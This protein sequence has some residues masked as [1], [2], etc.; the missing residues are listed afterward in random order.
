MQK[1]K[2]QQP[3]ERLNPHPAAGLTAQQA[4]QRAQ[5]GWAN[6]PPPSLG[7]T[8]ARIFW[9][10]IF[11]FYNLVFV[12]LAGCL[13]AVGAWRDMLF[14]G[15]VVCNAGI[16]ILQELRVRA[17]LQKAAVLT[18]APV[19]VVRDGREQL[20]PP[21]QLVLDDVVRFAAG[22]QVCADA[23]VLAGLVE[24]NEALLTGEADPVKKQPGDPLLSGSVVV[25]GEC[26]ARLD[27][28]GQQSYA[29]RLTQ[30]ARRQKRRP[31]GLVRD[32]DR[33]LRAVGVLLAPFGVFMGVRQCALPGTSLR[34]A[35]S[36]T[37]AALCGM[38]PEG[39]YLLVSV[40]LAVGVLRLARQRTLVHEMACIENLARV[41]TLCLDKTGTLTEG[42]LRAEALLAVGDAAPQ[43]NAPGRAITGDAAPEN[44]APGDLAA[45]SAAPGS[46]I[47]GE[48]PA[49]SAAPDAAEARLAALLGG[50]A[51]AAAAPNATIRALADAYSAP[52]LASTAQVPFS[53]QRGWSAQFVP[54]APGTAA[55]RAPAGQNEDGQA[56]AAGQNE[57]GQEGTGPSAPGVWYLLGAPERLAPGQNAD[58]LKPW[59]AAGR[60]V[61]AFAA[62]Q[63]AV[64]R[65]ALT[66][67]HTLLGYVVL[68]DTLRPGVQDT[69]RYFQ[70]QGVAV[71]VLS[72]DAPAAV[73]RIAQ[74]AGVPNAQRQADMSALSPQGPA[75]WAAFAR[76]HTVFGRVSPEQKRQLIA[77]L[78][79]AGHTVAMLGD[80]VN[81][82]PALK[83][84]DCSIAMAAGSE[85]ARQ[86]SQIVLL[87]S[88]FAA[89]PAILCEGRRVIQNVGR[90]AS[91]F[92]VKNIFSFFTAAAMLLAGRPYPLVPIQIT[93]ISGLLIGAPSFLLTF[94]PCCTRPRG[95]F[96]PQAIGKALPGGLTAAAAMLL[97]SF[98]GGRMGLPVAEVSSACTLLAGVNGLCVL[99]LLC[100][101]LTRLRAAV[102]GLMALG[103]FGATSFLPGFFG[104]QPFSPRGWGLVCALGAAVPAV[105]CALVW[106]VHLGRTYFTGKRASAR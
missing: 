21:D 42:S 100:W 48:A 39:L 3:A 68:A 87:D 51:R 93:L 74:L 84:A 35:V 61:L 33:W 22:G 59:L 47:T 58:L 65:D 104:I 38:I 45:K 10:N 19:R 75:D 80:G 60:R 55:S 78:R 9:D 43:D 81:D 71:K 57:E 72:G 27:R 11:T 53:S 97:A 85:A 82:L 34:Y 24:V 40:A 36:S 54:D 91:L 23:V 13:A 16:G 49:K 4:R 32:L 44:A 5:G 18:Q 96:L 30:N 92:L 8:T 94:E 106:L 86:A 56:G 31:A 25:A 7:K 70:Q 62:G 2:P 14:L 12:F 15:V 102:I 88:N 20:L 64:R 98:L 83:E 28:V 73:G 29:A 105:Q 17:V 26:A 1:T 95:R 52:P 41:D 76:Q 69:L 50:F 37:V 67:R 89:L 90:S 99:A 66:G 101:P 46:A 6:T 63:N 79:K 103:F 77:G